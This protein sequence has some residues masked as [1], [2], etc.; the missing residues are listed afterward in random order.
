MCD[1]PLKPM[2]GFNHKLIAHCKPGSE[3][4]GMFGMIPNG[5]YIAMTFGVTAHIPKLCA[6]GPS[7]RPLH[8]QVFKGA[9]KVRILPQPTK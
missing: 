4:S 8:L 6:K 9:G 3:C 7:F 2:V 5:Q 1:F